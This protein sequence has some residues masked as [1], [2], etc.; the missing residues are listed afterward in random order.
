MF[1]YKTTKITRC[2]IVFI[3]KQLQS[4]IALEEAYRRM[5]NSAVTFLK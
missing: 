1:T 3:N 4:G 5:W 2:Q